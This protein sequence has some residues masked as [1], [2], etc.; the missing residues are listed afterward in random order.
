MR[1]SI[2]PPRLG[3]LLAA[4]ASPVRILRNGASARQRR[5]APPAPRKTRTKIHTRAA[6][7]DPITRPPTAAMGGSRA[8]G[9]EKLDRHTG[10]GAGRAPLSDE[11]HFE[12]VGVLE[13]R[14][15]GLRTAGVRVIVDEHQ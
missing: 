5:N 4:V 9:I 13:V 12:A 10:S 7:Y 6:A 1:A 3:R 11:F 2:G 15:V 14:G 8:A